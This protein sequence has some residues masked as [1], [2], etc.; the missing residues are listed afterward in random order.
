MAT[1]YQSLEFQA[2]NPAYSIAIFRIVVYLYNIICT[3][4]GTQSKYLL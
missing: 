3:F 1:F 2:T 4:T